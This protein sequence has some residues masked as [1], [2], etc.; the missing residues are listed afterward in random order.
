MKLEV[1][2]IQK[3]IN[4][5]GYSFIPTEF[6][7]ETLDMCYYGINNIKGEHKEI[8]LYDLD[9]NKEICRMNPIEFMKHNLDKDLNWGLFSRYQLFSEDDLIFLQN[10]V[11]WQTIVCSH[12]LSCEF[13]RKMKK[14]I[15]FQLI[16]RTQTLNE[17]F[18]WEFR[19]LLDHDLILNN[20]IMSNEFYKKYKTYLAG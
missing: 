8:I 3:G 19:D 13:M 4:K 18:I 11:D 10:Y 7:L 20:Q 12:T 2:K 16:S 5:V 14:F 6:P 9:T 15:P 17:D 1:L